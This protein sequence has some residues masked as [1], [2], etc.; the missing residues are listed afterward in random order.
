MQHFTQVFTFMTS[1]TES[2]KPI[3]SITKPF[4]RDNKRH[5]TLYSIHL[6]LNLKRHGRDMGGTWEGQV[7]HKPLQNIDLKLIGRDGSDFI[8]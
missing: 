2:R 7:F 3:K 1:V 4:G 6:H 5:K 8:Y